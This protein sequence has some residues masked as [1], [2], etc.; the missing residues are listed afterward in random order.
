MSTLPDDGEQEKE[1]SVLEFVDEVIKREN[2]K[3]IA[4][5]KKNKMQQEK[6]A[7]VNSY[8]AVMLDNG[9]V[10]NVKFNFYFLENIWTQWVYAKTFGMDKELQKLKEATNGGVF[11]SGDVMFFLDDVKILFRP[12]LYYNSS[13]EQK[14]N[15]DMKNAMISHYIENTIFNQIFDEYEDEYEDE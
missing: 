12:E 3:I 7:L 9:V 14:M 15:A 6:K 8:G 2:K 1:Q 11:N 5:N 13:N 4:E 10:I